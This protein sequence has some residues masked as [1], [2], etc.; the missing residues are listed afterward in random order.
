MTKKRIKSLS[1]CITFY[2]E[3]C[4]ARRQSPRTV[5][6]KQSNLNC[7]V[8]WCATKKLHKVYQIKFLFLEDYRRHLNK[9]RQPGT[10]K[11]LDIATIR[12]KL[13]IVKTFFDRLYYL[14]V[15]S[16]NPAVKFELPTVPRRLPSDYLSV[17][18]IELVLYQTLFGRYKG[19]RDRAIMETYYATGVRRMELAR[20]AL[21]DLDSDARLLTIRRG[22][23]Q[24]DRRV[25]IAKRACDWIE[26]YL[27]KV[28]PI[29]ANLSSGTV[30]F[31]TNSGKQYQEGQLTYIASKY[32]K[33]AGIDKRGACN[34]FRHSTATLMHENGADIRYVQEMLGHADIS[35]TQ[36][37]THVAIK[38]LR[39]VYRNTHPAN[40]G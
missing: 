11:P 5:E 14:E 26:L 36:V 19:I 18:E 10:Q 2:L 28:R 6:G 33:R 25:P 38:R 39:E 13:T 12:N 8:R 37:Y 40:D 7:F 35:T 27:N 22:K 3:D 29:L 15:I 1:D 30:L 16:V 32:V 24:K 21:K 17:P 34:L 31:L 23:G 20:L 9:Y 4:L